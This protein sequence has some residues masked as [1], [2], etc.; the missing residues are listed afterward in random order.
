[1]AIRTPT[2][3]EI[4]A[5][6]GHLDEAIAIYEHLVEE[7][8]DYTARLEDLKCRAERARQ[9]AQQ[10]A[11]VEGLRVLLRRVHSRARTS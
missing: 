4:Y 9:A 11:R 10:E 8:Q 7:G 2:L 3:A 1:M 6:Q 5:R